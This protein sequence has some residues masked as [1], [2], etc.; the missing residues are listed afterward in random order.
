M[1]LTVRRRLEHVVT[2]HPHT[3]SQDVGKLIEFP[4]AKSLTVSFDPRSC[5]APVVA[6]AT[7]Y[8]TERRDDHWGESK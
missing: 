4:G 2:A 8:K 1:L 5:C 3:V 7:V 6:W